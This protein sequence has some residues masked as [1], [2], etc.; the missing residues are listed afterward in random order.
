MAQHTPGPWRVFTTPDNTK[1]I[2]IGDRDG[3]G[4]ADCGFGVWRGG[5]EE[6]RAN[7]LLMAAAPDLLVALKW[8]IDDID[9]THT[10]MVDFDRNVE[11]A[12]KALARA[13]AQS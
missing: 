3:E 11:R 7:A 6:A 5:S 9:G 1:I 8:F 13:E 10:V 4:I 12:R 2:G